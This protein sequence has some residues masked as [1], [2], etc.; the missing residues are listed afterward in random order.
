MAIWDYLPIW[1]Q[2]VSIVRNILLLLL[3]NKEA[4]AGL[5]ESERETLKSGTSN[6]DCL[7]GGEFS[8][9]K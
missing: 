4:L 6:L 7:G 5:M 9:S 2:E 1:L 3:V 8:V